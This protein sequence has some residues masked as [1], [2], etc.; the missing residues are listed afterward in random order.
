MLGTGF[1][2]RPAEVR[3]AAITA[4]AQLGEQVSAD[5]LDAYVAHRRPEIRHQAAYAL[6]EVGHP[7]GLPTLA[8]LL[9]DP[10]PIVQVAAAGAIVKLQPE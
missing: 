6:G 3:M 5:S 10:N 7:N 4:L 8:R 9:H 2:R 1:D